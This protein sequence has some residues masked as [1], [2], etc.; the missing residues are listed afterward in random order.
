MSFRVGRLD[1]AT[2]TVVCHLDGSARQATTQP[3]CQRTWRSTRLAPLTV[4]AVE[5]TVAMCRAPT[6]H[7]PWDRRYSSV[8]AK[9]PIAQ[10]ALGRPTGL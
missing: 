2:A 1:G 9:S 4:A 3:Q 5:D 6:H 7:R 8:L 10:A